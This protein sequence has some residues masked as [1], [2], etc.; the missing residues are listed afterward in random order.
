MP[1]LYLDRYYILLCVPAFI[2]ALI[3]NSMVNR[4]YSKYSKVRNQRGLTGAQ[5]AYNV[6]MHN[7]INNVKIEKTRLFLYNK[8]TTRAS[9]I[10]WK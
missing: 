5:A 1:F 9:Y 10:V 2:I 8:M 3:A 4:A 7:G 6:L